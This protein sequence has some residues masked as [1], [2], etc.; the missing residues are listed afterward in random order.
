MSCFDEE[1]T[2]DF[3]FSPNLLPLLTASPQD[4][5][6]MLTGQG[7]KETLPFSYWCLLPG[8]YCLQDQ[9]QGAGRHRLPE[10]QKLPR[11]PKCTAYLRLAGSR[12]SE[13]T[14]PAEA[15]PAAPRL[16]G[17]PDPATGA[18]LRWPG[19]APN[20]GGQAEERPALTNLAKRVLILGPAPHTR[21]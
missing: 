18:M 10:N 13:A 8:C 6:W 5:C 12:R 2:K 16:C 19:P 1:I 11:A 21:S 4:H 15:A 7:L 20:P 9:K 14:L 17:A 3:F